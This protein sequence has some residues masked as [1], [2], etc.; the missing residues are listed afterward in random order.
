MFSAIG[1]QN[2]LNSNVWVST[3]PM[4]SNGSLSAFTPVYFRCCQALCTSTLMTYRFCLFVAEVR[5][6]RVRCCRR[7]YQQCVDFLHMPWWV[8]VGN[9][10]F[11]KPSIDFSFFCG[12][13]GKC[14]CL[15][16][17]V[18][19]VQWGGYTEHFW[20]LSSNDSTGTQEKFHFN[21][22]WVRLLV[23]VEILSLSTRCLNVRDVLHRSSRCFLPQTRSAKF[24]SKTR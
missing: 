14:I 9:L 5:L 3:R 22:C 19:T 7:P 10:T 4:I 8:P 17:M 15:L 23:N 2:S 21:L 6:F 13:F 16:F 1:L 20:Q 24:C 11:F 18:L 12:W